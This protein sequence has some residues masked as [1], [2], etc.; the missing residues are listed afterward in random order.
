[1]FSMALGI[2]NTYMLLE[3]LMPLFEEE[4]TKGPGN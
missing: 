4:S 3:T 1:M 2:N